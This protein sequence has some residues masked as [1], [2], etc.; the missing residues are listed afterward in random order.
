MATARRTR[1]IYFCDEQ[2]LRNDKSTEVSKEFDPFHT[3][4]VKR[5]VKRCATVYVSNATRRPTETQRMTHPVRHGPQEVG[6]KKHL[7]HLFSSI[8]VAIGA[9]AETRQSS[10]A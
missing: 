9:K 7:L 5:Y 2:N 4:C 1:H 10:L 6:G 8:I 3:G